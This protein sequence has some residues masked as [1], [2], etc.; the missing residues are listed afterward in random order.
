MNFGTR[1]FIAVFTVIHIIVGSFSVEAFVRSHL[2]LSDQLHQREHSTPCSLHK[3]FETSPFI[4]SK[5]SMFERKLSSN[6]D[7][8]IINQE[9]KTKTLLDVSHAKNGFEKMKSAINQEGAASFSFLIS[10]CGFIL[11]PFLDSYHSLFGVLKYDNPLTLQLWSSSPDNPA[12]V[13]TIWVPP[14]FGLAAFII[15]WLTILLDNFFEESEPVSELLRRT[16]PKILMGISFF[17]FQYYV[18]GILV[19][20]GVSRLN[21]LIIMSLFSA[22]GYQVFDRTKAGLLTSFATAIGGPLIEV[23]LIN[24]FRHTSG[25]D[26]LSDWGYH[27]IDSG[28]FGFLPLWTAPVYF[29]G[30]PAVGNLARGIWNQVTSESLSTDEKP[31]CPVCNNT[32]CVPCPNCDGVGYY[33]SYNQ[34]IKCNCCKGRGFVICRACFSEYDEDPNDLEAIRELMRRMPD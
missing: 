30:G 28:E 29:L 20:S 18:S 10:S 22:V 3:F 17:T 7:L 14:L 32:R 2:K 5:D 19:Y 26:I 4:T 13:T 11:G 12:L 21:L 31:N 23:G 34:N 9:M 24:Y 15:G 16:G 25:T 27:Y 1:K 6:D 8:D 33:V